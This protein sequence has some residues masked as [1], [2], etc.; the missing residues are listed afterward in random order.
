MNAEEQIAV[1]RAT[2]TK[3]PREVKRQRTVAVLLATSTVISLLFLVYAFRIKQGSEHAVTSLQRQVELLQRENTQ[4][5]LQLESAAVLA[6]RVEA[7]TGEAVKS[8][9]NELQKK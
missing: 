7:R 9:P 2:A 3:T 8:A 1:L 5:K 4:L 6:K